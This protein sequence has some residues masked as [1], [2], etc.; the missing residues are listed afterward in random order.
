MTLREATLDAALHQ[1]T[2]SSPAIFVSC[3]RKGFD[4]EPGMG[5][6]SMAQRVRFS[7]LAQTGSSGLSS[8]NIML[9]WSTGTDYHDGGLT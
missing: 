7:R 8:A 3:A 6:R 1:E 5:A 2:R 9:E 4:A